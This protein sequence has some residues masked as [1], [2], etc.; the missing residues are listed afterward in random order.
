MTEGFSDYVSEDWELSG[1][2]YDVI[3]D[4][5]VAIPVE[6]GDVNIYADVY[7][8]D[9]EEP[10]PAIIGASPYNKEYQ[11]APIKPKSI[12]PQ[13][14]W[15]ESGDPR[16]FARRGYA[17]IIISV[18]GTGK[19][20]G[21][22]RHI[23]SREVQ[24][25]IDAMDWFAERDWCDGNFGMFGVSYFASL[26]KHVAA[27]DPDRLK[28]IFAPWAFS[29]PYRDIM[30]QG[31]ILGTFVL[32]W[33]S[34]LDNP[35]FYEWPRGDRSPA[36]YEEAIEDAK[37]DPELHAHEKIMAAIANP[38]DP[39]N[40]ELAEIVL[41][42]LYN[43]YWRKR[44]LDYSES[45][46]PAYLGSCWGS[47]G[48]HLPGAF[49]DWVHWKG[50]KK[51]FIGPDRY[52]DRPVYQLQTKAVRWFD[53]WIKS[54]ENGVMDE[55][56]VKLFV[57]GRND[58]KET[59]DWPIPE[60]IWQRIYLHED[61]LLL[62]RDYW[63]NE[64]SITYEDGPFRRESVEFF[65]PPLVEKT[66]VI[67]PARLDL[68]ASSTDKEAHFH[69]EL[70]ALGPDGSEE[71]LTRGWLRGT[72]RTVDESKSTPWRVHHPHDE[73]VP[74]EPGKVHEFNINIRATG[75][76][77]S[78]GERIGL[79]ISSAD[80]GGGWHDEA[81]SEL[82]WK[83]AVAMGHIARQDVSRVTVYHESEHPSNLLLPVT[84][85]NEM[86]LFYSGGQATK[87]RGELPSRE[88]RREKHPP[89]RDGAGTESP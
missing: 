72:H 55:A 87:Q 67:G 63:P 75:Y 22:F 7:R 51:L 29:D 32:E 45:N 86:G 49:R 38:E 50:P 66:E 24:D 23:D 47:Y 76:S 43:E 52:L 36:E 11:A 31:G 83:Q 26:A 14:G 17:H 54:V 73:R 28:A 80:V 88:L 35:R 5:D 2:T 81:M 34:H 70:L 9:T 12:S 19:S 25:V 18:R 62:D 69:I 20:G 27:R 13:V 40:A 42:P 1:R 4:R 16:Y 48:I 46:V 56:P 64:G 39:G 85:G 30:Y 82:S 74:L 37:A 84:A 65:S 10:V 79:R 21:R 53:Y 6:R 57:M 68:F 15:I 8:P 77:F 33:D 61:G 58:W 59:E 60:T 71:E 89:A 41:N 44:R 78:S 3:V